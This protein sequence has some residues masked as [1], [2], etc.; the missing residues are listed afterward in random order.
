MTFAQRRNRLTKHISARVL[1]VKRSMSVSSEFLFHNTV[2]TGLPGFEF[3]VLIFLLCFLTLIGQTERERE[4]E[5]ER[6][7]RGVVITRGRQD[8]LFI[9]FSYIDAKLHINVAAKS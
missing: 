4:S 9:I 6:E 8:V 3:T 2:H 5:S 1:V 7:V